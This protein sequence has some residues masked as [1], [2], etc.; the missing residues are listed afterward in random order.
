MIAELRELFERYPGNDDF[1]LE[2]QTRAGPALPALRRRL[3]DRRA[4]TAR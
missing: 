3:P 4:A 1:V 2:M